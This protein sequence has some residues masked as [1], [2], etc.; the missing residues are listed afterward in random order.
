[1]SVTSKELVAALDATAIEVTVLKDNRF[2]VTS[3]RELR[4]EDLGPALAAAPLAN[5][6]FVRDV[7]PEL[8]GICPTRG[9]ADYA[10]AHAERTNHCAAHVMGCKFSVRGNSVGRHEQVCPLLLTKLLLDKGSKIENFDAFFAA[11]VKLRGADMIGAS[12]KLITKINRQY[13]S[14]GEMLERA[15][16]PSMRALDVIRNV[17]DIDDKE[18][19]IAEGMLNVARAEL[20]ERAA[21]AKSPK[22]KAKIRELIEGVE[23]YFRGADE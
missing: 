15:R 22:A 19:S 6:T 2:R 18:G 11:V 7:P 9:P 12:A 13:G 10:T 20:M 16:K 8:R 5:V 21:K 1:M 23:R 17:L 3:V 4:G 14:Y